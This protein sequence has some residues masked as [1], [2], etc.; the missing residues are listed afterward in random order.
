[1]DD[2]SL[3]E[4]VIENI[5][6]QELREERV[7][8][9]DEIQHLSHIIDHATILEDQVYDKALPGCQVQLGNHKICY[10]LRLV[11]TYE[12]DPREGK[13]SCS[14][15]IGQSLIGRR[16][17]DEVLVPTPLGRINFNIVSIA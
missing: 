11:S 10:I 8:I 15:P 2:I 5:E 3:A 6:F 13:I 7:R 14:S 12:A 16:V 1:M 4:E 9:Q 17:G